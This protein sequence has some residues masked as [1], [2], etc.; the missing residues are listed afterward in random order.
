MLKLSSLSPYHLEPFSPLVMVVIC[1]FFFFFSSR[2]RHTRL[3]GD[4]SSDVCSSDLP[5]SAELKERQ[6]LHTL[7]Q[8]AL[9]EM[10]LAFKDVVV[11]AEM[12]AH[13]HIQREQL[14]VGERMSEI[15]AQL[16]ARA[17]FVPFQLLERHELRARTELR[18]WSSCARG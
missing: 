3:Q 14:S 13:H 5:T 7:P 1:F 4:W 16:G 10:L 9:Q 17:E 12:F 2:R 15:L 11:R 18:F 8:I 6:L